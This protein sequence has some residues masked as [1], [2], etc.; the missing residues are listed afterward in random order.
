M[1]ESA[2]RQQLA[3]AWTSMKTYT[4]AKRFVFPLLGL[5]ALLYGSF[6]LARPPLLDRADALHAEIAREILL[7]HDWVTLYSNGVRALENSPLLYWSMATSYR[8]FGVADWAARL[9][10]ALYTLALFFAVFALGRRLFASVNA[11]FYSALVLL[12]SFGVFLFTRILVPDV[13]LCLWITLAILFFWRSLEEERPSLVT[14]CGFAACCALGALTRSLLG[15]LLPLA[16]VFVF[17]FFTRN[18]RHMLRWHPLPGSLVFV[19]IAAPWHIAAAFAN[20]P[21]G[22]PAGLVPTP[23]NVHGFLWIYFVNGQILSAFNRQVPRGHITL[24]LLIFWALLLVWLMPWVLFSIGA[25]RRLTVRDALLRKPLDRSQ[26]VLLLL[27]LWAAVVMVFFSFCAR[28]Q[29]YILPALPALALLAG[30]W[31]AQDEDCPDGECRPG[32]VI[33][34][35]L[36]ALGIVAAAIAAYFAIKTPPAI[37]D[38]YGTEILQWRHHLVSLTAPALGAFRVPLV[39][40]ALAVLVGVSANLWF[41]IRSNVR[42]ANC[43]L[44]GMMVC[45]LIAAHL[46]LYT[47]SPVIS[48]ALLAE[49]IQPEITSGDLV[50]INGK[51]E[52]A[53]TLN[54]YLERQVHMLNGRRGDLW[55]GSFFTDTPAIFEDD[56]SLAKLWNGPGRIFLWTRTAKVPTLPGPVYVIAA[57]GGKEIVSNE[58]NSGGATF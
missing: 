41:R 46:A 43:F 58:P 12:T 54:F 42:L 39:I 51:Y 32:K 30:G 21:Q 44:A 25:L 4:T 17:L 27:G 57:S 24:P 5:W 7:R 11:G 1:P 40:A 20:P 38:T 3:C 28:Q 19:L 13:I 50:V 6:S 10:L 49:S 15:V 31:L 36:F 23:G 55:Y 48:S 16:V 56:A 47:F 35:I 22:H 14:A 37:H 33:A 18:L 45:F 2:T 8:L 52:N 9:P 34:W 26:Q 29:Y 53:V